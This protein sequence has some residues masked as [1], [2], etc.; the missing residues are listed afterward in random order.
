MLSGLSLSRRSASPMVVVGESWVDVD[1][2]VGIASNSRTFG[3][4]CRSILSIAVD[5]VVAL[6]VE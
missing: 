5:L 6:Q 2:A 1:C 3:S 4:C